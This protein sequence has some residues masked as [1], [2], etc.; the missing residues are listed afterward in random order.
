MRK[1]VIALV[2]ACLLLLTA[3]GESEPEHV[4]KFIEGRMVIMNETELVGV[5]CEYTNNSNDTSIPCDEIN[6]LAFQ[7][8]KEIP[9]MVYTGQETDGALQCDNSIQAETSANVVW[10]F[11]PI[12]NSEVTV[13]FTDGQKYSFDLETISE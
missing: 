12:D 2:A 5:F 8:G 1:K 3:C 7:N 9:V 13:E 11:D 6:V 4:L 10:L